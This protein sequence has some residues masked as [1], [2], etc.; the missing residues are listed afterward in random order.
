MSKSQNFAFHFTSYRIARTRQATPKAAAP[1]NVRCCEAALAVGRDADVEAAPA[2]KPDDDEALDDE[3]E[4]DV[5]V[6][7]LNVVAFTPAAMVATLGMP[8]MTPLESVIVV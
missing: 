8:V 4:L 1:A 2:L 6:T 7:V 5:L 3:A